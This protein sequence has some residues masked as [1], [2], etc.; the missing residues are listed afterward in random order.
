[1]SVDYSG[2]VRVVPSQ[3]KQ[4][5]N[6]RPIDNLFKKITANQ[7]RFDEF[8]QLTVDNGEYVLDEYVRNLK[9]KIDLATE[10]QIEKLREINSELMDRV[11]CFKAECIQKLRLEKI[12]STQMNELKEEFENIKDTTENDSLDEMQIKEYIHDLNRL[13]KSTINE[14][15]LVKNHV[16]DNKDCFF[17]KSKIEFNEKSIGS[18]TIKSLKSKN[19]DLF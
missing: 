2:F 4:M 7:K 11:E 5:S 17:V 9:F 3:N 14:I 18:L 12:D 6:Q 1:M 10:K 19:F 13:E 8:E 15:R 16:F